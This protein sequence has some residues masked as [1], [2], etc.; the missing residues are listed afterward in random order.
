MADITMCEGGQCPM[1][2]DCYRHTATPGEYRQSYF[3]EI[4]MKEISVVTHKVFAECEYYLDN[5]GYHD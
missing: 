4:P 5:W 3:S 1:K 2:D